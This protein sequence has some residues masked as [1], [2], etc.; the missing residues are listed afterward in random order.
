MAET[1]GEELAKI[2]D[3]DL[4]DIYDSY[5][6]NLA[7]VKERHEQNIKNAEKISQKMSQSFR[8]KTKRE[9][10][11]IQTIPKERGDEEE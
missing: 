5:V 11:Q 3:N 2:L 6:K 7:K 1:I 8:P 10:E 4:T 9:A